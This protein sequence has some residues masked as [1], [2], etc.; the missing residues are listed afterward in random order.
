MASPG[1]ARCNLAR[2]VPFST[3]TGRSNKFIIRME[4]GV[5]H[6]CPRHVKSAVYDSCLRHPVRE[7]RCQLGLDSCHRVVADDVGYD[8]QM[9]SRWHDHVL[10]E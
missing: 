8:I 4:I 6:T 1:V 7:V 3:V 9:A 5:G 2:E 10:H